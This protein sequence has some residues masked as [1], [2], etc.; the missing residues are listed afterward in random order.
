[1]VCVPTEIL[2]RH[3]PKWK[4]RGLRHGI[5]EFKVVNV[6]KRTY[7]RNISGFRLSTP[8]LL[9]GTACHVIN[10]ITKRIT[11]LY[12]PATNGTFDCQPQCLLQGWAFHVI[13]N[14]ITW[15]D[16]HTKIITP[17]YPWRKVQ[18]AALVKP[19]V[20]RHSWPFFSYTPHASLTKSDFWSVEKGI[21]GGGGNLSKKKRTKLEQTEILFTLMSAYFKRLS[22]AGRDSRYSCW[23]CTGCV[24]LDRNCYSHYLIDIPFKYLHDGNWN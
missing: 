19:G 7:S 23:S 1:V 21:W 16:V 6:Q 5:L 14:F 18:P 24:A 11:K 3:P 13:N 2:T 22:S 9:Q 17:L 12:S 8:Y 15:Y 4:S 20:Q 10:S